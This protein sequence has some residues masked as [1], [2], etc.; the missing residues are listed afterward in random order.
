ML[1]LGQYI[2]RGRLQAAG[3]ISLTAV[4]SLLMPPLAYL[5]T[6]VP[7]ALVT[8]RRGPAIGMQIIIVALV[9]TS[10][11]AYLANL[12]VAVAPAFALWI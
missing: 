10:V 5:L 6:G 2:T 7:V 1:A 12:Q 3:I 9:A 11:F 4:L 8:L